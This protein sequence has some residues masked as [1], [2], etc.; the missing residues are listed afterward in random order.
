MR[1]HRWA[2]AGAVAVAVLVGGLAVS[3]P[4]GADPGLNGTYRLEY[5]GAKRMIA[6]SP[7]PIANTSATYSFTTRCAGEGCNVDGVLL[8]ATDTEAVSAHNPDITMQFVDGSWQLSL[9]YDSPC[10][11]GG[12]RNQMLSWVLTPQPGSDA[13]T[14]TRTVSTVGNSCPGDEPGPL[15]QPITAT[16]VGTA[17]PGVL[18]TR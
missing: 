2:T 6:G 11:G 18:P 14:G 8:N 12:E 1:V 5:D 7:S 16:R 15:S 10:E 9:P 4:A 3:L 17:A 13:L